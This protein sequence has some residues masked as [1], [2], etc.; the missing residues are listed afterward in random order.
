MWT[1]L[2]SFGWVM[3]LSLFTPA[4]ITFEAMCLASFQHGGPHWKQLFAMPIP[5][6]NIFAVKMLCCGLLVGASIVRDPLGLS[7]ILASD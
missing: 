6:W 7:L 1:D 2:L 5:R 3:W 4:L